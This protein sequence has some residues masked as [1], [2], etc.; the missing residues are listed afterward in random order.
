MK[1]LLLLLLLAHR[2]VS[3]EIDSAVLVKKLEEADFVFSGNIESNFIIRKN[4]EKGSENELLKKDYFIDFW[5]EV[6]KITDKFKGVEDS[7]IRKIL[8]YRRYPSDFAKIMGESVDFDRSGYLDIESSK[9]ELL[10]VVRGDKKDDKSMGVNARYLVI[11][12]S[13]LD[14][15]TKKKLKVMKDSVKR[16]IK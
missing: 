14:Q 16:K 6:V 10:F 9:K 2:G 15:K 13:I 5:M 4:A 12:I 7:E 3:D 11:P 8:V 1:Y